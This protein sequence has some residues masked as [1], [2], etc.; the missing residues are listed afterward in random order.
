V[1]VLV[2]GASRGIGRAV[3]RAFGAAGH[4]V[5]AGY[6][7]DRSGAESVVREIRAAGGGGEAFKADVS[8]PAQARALV[9]AALNKWDRLD[10]L[11]NNAGV[12]RDRTI[13]KMSEEEWRRVL[14]VN[15]SGA[16]WVLQAAA[17]A[18]AREKSGSILNVASIM[19]VKG[20]YG[21]A[22][23][24]AAKAGLVALT[25]SAA[26]ELG[27]FNVRVNAILPGFHMTDMNKSFTPAQ[28]EKITGEHAL[29]RLP[30]LEELAR[31]VV[32]AVSLTSVSGQ[33]FNFESRVL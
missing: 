24:S 17:Q 27:R 30:D 12:T 7:G 29:G 11:V 10:V 4:N 2:T 32:H 14:D 6:E 18:M 1:N 28:V 26:R 23:Y 19:A 31:F 8:D 21:C 20:G 25:K 3:A 15:L 16:F 33:V 5:L 22:N 9:G 13:L